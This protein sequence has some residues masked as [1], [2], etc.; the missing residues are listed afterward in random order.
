[1]AGKRRLRS[2]SDEERELWQRVTR[3][4]LPL[5]PAAAPQV[6]GSASHEIESKS[7]TKL[8]TPSEAAGKPTLSTKPVA[9]PS[10]QKKAV[11]PAPAPFD[12]KIGRLI[13][14]GRRPIDAR[15]DLHGLRQQ[16]AYFALR[17]FLSRCQAAGHRHVLIITG[18][19]GGTSGAE[20]E[21]DYWNSEQR[22]VLRR[23]VPQWLSE[24]DFR[25]NV[26]SFTES[27]VRHGGSGALYVTIRRRSRST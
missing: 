11:Q 18:K 16:D 6:N 27:S 23:M 8:E 21:R 25:T 3:H 2:L 20:E 10:A 15:L 19:G 26:V 12:P 4:D 14:R 5:V 13:A 1:M 17:G 7:A 22:G 24:P 9:S